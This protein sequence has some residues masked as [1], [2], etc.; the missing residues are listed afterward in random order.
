MQRL[1]FFSA[2]VLTLFAA[3]CAP[4]PKHLTAQ[5]FENLYLI[6]QGN[7]LKD[8]TYIGMTNGAVYMLEWK[9]PLLYGKKPRHK[10][11]FTETNNLSADFLEKMRHDADAMKNVKAQ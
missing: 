5:D 7:S 6:N 8:Y 10:T 9:A 1:Y 2:I 3:G 11:F 4:G